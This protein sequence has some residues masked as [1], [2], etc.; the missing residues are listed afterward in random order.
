MP[1][2][3][4][5][6]PSCCINQQGWATCLDLFKLRLFQHCI[7]PLYSN[8]RHLHTNFALA[9]TPQQFGQGA[10]FCCLLPP[11]SFH[12]TEVQPSN[13]PTRRVAFFPCD[14]CLDLLGTNELRS[15]VAMGPPTSRML[16]GDAS[17]SGAAE[18][19]AAESGAA[20]SGSAESGFSWPVFLSKFQGS[21]ALR[22]LTT[23]GV[24]HVPS[25]SNPC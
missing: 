6:F 24:S 20:E 12:N 8:L 1:S 23:P 11:T 13:I 14:Q 10:A 15:A 17:T 19:G 3:H 5:S 4:R 7:N 21:P 25:E 18:S 22:S 2:A 16:P 9:S